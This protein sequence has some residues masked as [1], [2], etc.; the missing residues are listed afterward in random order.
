MS[1]VITVLMAGMG[2][3]GPVPGCGPQVVAER[4]ANGPAL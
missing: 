4:R 1:A 3:A 2:H